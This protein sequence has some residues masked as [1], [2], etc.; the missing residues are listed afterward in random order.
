M[1]LSSR[2]PF[3]LNRRYPWRSA[4]TRAASTPLIQVTVAITF[5]SSINTPTGAAYA[6]TNVVV[7]DS[8]GVAQPAVAVTPTSPSFV[9]SVA[10]GAGTVVATDVDVNGATLSSISQVFTVTPVTAIVV[11]PLG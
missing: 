11:T 7:T 1:R 3:N 5:S 4:K 2:W 10:A 9:A 8:T 6:K